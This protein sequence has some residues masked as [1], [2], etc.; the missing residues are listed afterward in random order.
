VVI[1]T[2]FMDARPLRRVTEFMVP[3]LTGFNVLLAA[4]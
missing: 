3:S 1:S 4:G 2:T